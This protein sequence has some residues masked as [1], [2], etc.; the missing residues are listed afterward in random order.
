[1]SNY[2]SATVTPKGKK[3]KY[4]HQVFDTTGHLVGKRLSNKIYRFVVMARTNKAFALQ[5]A[6]DQIR[7]CEQYLKTVTT[8]VDADFYK[9]QIEIYRAKVAQIE[10]MVGG[11]SAYISGYSN[12]NK[13]SLRKDQ[14]LVELVPVIGTLPDGR[15]AY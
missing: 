14:D 13:P 4:L 3:Q 9:G 10:T 15:V 12:S 2:Y 11:F 1:M 5:N 8:D 7:H 6:K